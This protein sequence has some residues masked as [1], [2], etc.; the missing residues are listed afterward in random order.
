[1]C[2]TQYLRRCFGYW[3]PMYSQKW[4]PGDTRRQFTRYFTCRTSSTHALRCVLTFTSRPFQPKDGLPRGKV[5]TFPVKQQVAFQPGTV[6]PQLNAFTTWPKRHFNVC[7]KNSDYIHQLVLAYHHTHTWCHAGLKTVKVSQL[8]IS[9]TKGL[10]HASVSGHIVRLP[11]RLRLCLPV[12]VN[13]S[14]QLTHM[15]LTSHTGHNNQH[16]QWRWGETKPSFAQLLC[17][18][19]VQDNHEGS[20]DSLCTSPE[21]CKLWLHYVEH[22]SLSEV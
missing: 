19:S 9:T 4:E 12:C 3:I 20:S 8:E 14:L 2:N 13:T 7:L 1:M 10:L 6:G 22:L 11:S 21:C 15:Y 18:P 16:E 17:K 5:N